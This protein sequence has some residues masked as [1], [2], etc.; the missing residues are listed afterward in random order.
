MMNDNNPLEVRM[1]VAAEF[2]AIYKSTL[3]MKEACDQAY[4]QYPNTDISLE[5]FECMWLAINTHICLYG[6]GKTKLENWDHDLKNL[7]QIAAA[8]VLSYEQEPNLIFATHRT[9]D[10]L[11]AIGIDSKNTSDMWLAIDAY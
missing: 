6:N 9:H 5:K 4:K 11:K 2:V 8:M 3:S 1:V 10:D 7:K